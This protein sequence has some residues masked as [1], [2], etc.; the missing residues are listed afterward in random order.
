MLTNKARLRLKTR[1]LPP[2]SRLA[3]KEQPD[4]NGIDQ[5]PIELSK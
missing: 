5:K 2:F 3:E 4:Y 1:E